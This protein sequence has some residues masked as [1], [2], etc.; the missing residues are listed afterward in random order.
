MRNLYLVFRRLADHGLNLSAQKCALF[1]PE[2]DYLGHRLGREGIRP[3]HS[4][5]QAIAEYPRP[6]VYFFVKVL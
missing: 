4:N 2:V 3:L 5:I 6:K 1:R